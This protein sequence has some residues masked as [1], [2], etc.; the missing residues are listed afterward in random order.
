MNNDDVK[1]YQEIEGKG[2]TFE[3]NDKKISIGNKLICNCEEDAILHLNID[4]K[5]IASVFINDGIKTMQKKP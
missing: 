3:L 1:K 4:G 2:I 5:H